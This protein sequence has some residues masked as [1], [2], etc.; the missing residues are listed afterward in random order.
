MFSILAETI[1]SNNTTISIEIAIRTMSV[2]F[3]I[4]AYKDSASQPVLYEIHVIC[5]NSHR[6]CDTCATVH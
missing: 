6:Q 1:D 2:D 4:M 3:Q 5:T